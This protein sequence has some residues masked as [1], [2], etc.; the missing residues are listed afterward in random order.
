[1]NKTLKYTLLTILSL[2]NFNL[3]HAS[4][5]MHSKTQGECIMQTPQYAPIND[6][7]FSEIITKSKNKTETFDSILN[8]FEQNKNSYY[9]FT[10]NYPLANKE[11]ADVFKKVLAI[12]AQQAHR[13]VPVIEHS[14]FIEPSHLGFI[15]QIQ[16]KDGP[17]VQERI[18]INQNPT[19][20]I[21]ISEW[22]NMHGQLLPDNFVAI[23]E[24]I[25][26]DGQWYF[27]GSYLYGTNPTESASEESMVEMF[28]TTDENMLKFIKN[29]DVEAIYNQLHPY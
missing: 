27:S 7:F 28:K 14:Q 1:M 19:Q 5:E 9:L 11:Q 8:F 25:E 17:L 22:A 18:L 21:F 29:E 15:R 4:T 6:K 16:I 3:V 24:V 12:K 13:F 2:L 10:F 23:N 20:V 26:K